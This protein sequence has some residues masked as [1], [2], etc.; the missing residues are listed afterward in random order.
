VQRSPRFAV[1]ATTS[2]HAPFQP[3]APFVADWGRL[4]RPD[5]YTPAQAAAALAAPLSVMQPLPPYLDSLRYQFAWLA[6]YLQQ[7]APRPLV[8][9]IVGDHQA[10]ALV[11]GPGASWDVPVHV[12]SDDPALLQRLLGSGFVPGLAPPAQALGPMHWLTRVLLKAF[13]AP[14]AGETPGVEHVAVPD[15]P[16]SAP[17]S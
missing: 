10:P 12:V 14:G 9:V 3:I 13:D 7:L 8:M 11:S 6:D 1:F 5:A 15:A 17:G 16:H 2:T 4:T